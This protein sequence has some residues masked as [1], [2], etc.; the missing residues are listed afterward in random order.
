MCKSIWKLLEKH[1]I[2]AQYTI[3]ATPQQNNVAKRSNQTLMD[4]V[5]SMMTKFI[6]PRSLW[7]YDVKT[8]V[9]F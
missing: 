4:I 9:H 5:R 8:V 2:C 6:L 1:D 7:M 3:T